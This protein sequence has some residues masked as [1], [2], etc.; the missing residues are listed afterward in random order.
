MRV[1]QSMIKDTMLRNLSQNVARLERLEQ[2][3]TSG[4][5]VSRPSDDPIALAAILR[6][7]SSTAQANQHLSNVDS[8]R[9]WMDAT[10]Q[11]LMSI[12]DNILRARQIAL[13]APN[14][15][16]SNSDRDAI[17]KELGALIG[18]V[19]ATGNY[20]LAGQY[21]FSG[22]QTRT[23]AFDGSTSPPTF[24]GNTNQIARIIDVDVTIPINVTGDQA[25]QPTLEALTKIRDAVV[26]NDFDAIRSGVAEL[27]TAHTKLLSAQAEI[28]ARTNRLESQRER[29]EDIKVNLARL[30]SETQDVDMPAVLSDYAVQDVVYRA[31]LQA[32]AKAIQP[33]LIDYLR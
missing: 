12:G 15:A 5:R 1:T 27:D 13:A 11:A 4:Q 25:I 8:A 3:I 14:T 26:A 2:Q 17:A 24:V 19:V 22:Q 20:Q 10:D 9:S 23:A 6:L 33:S 7:D 28:G 16:T 32:G 18:Q 30:R 29:L 31:S 21:I